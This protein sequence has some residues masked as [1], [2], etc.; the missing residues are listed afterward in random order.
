M[1]SNLLSNRPND[2]SLSFVQKTHSGFQNDRDSYATNSFFSNNLVRASLFAAG[3]YGAYKA[4]I[5]LLETKPKYLQ[6]ITKYTKLFEDR[7][8]NYIGRTFGIS[9]NRISP[10]RAGIGA[11]GEIETLHFPKAD[12]LT[13]SGNLSALGHDFQRKFGDHYDVLANAEEGLSFTRTS[14]SS[15]YIPFDNKPGMSVSFAD[16]KSGLAGT[17]FRLKKPLTEPKIGWSKSSSLFDRAYENLEALKRSQTPKSHPGGW[18]QA[19]NVERFLPVD[20]IKLG[21]EGETF[22]QKTKRVSSNVGQRLEIEGLNSAERGQKLL[23]DTLR[24]GLSQGTY[25][26]LA[27]I[28]GLAREGEKG[29]INGLLLKRVLPLYLGYQALKYADYLTGHKVSNAV[30]DTPLKLNVARAELTDRLPGARKVTDFYQNVVPGKQYAPLALPL[31]GAFLGGLGHYLKVAKGGFENPKLRDEASKLLPDLKLLKNVRNL[32][33]L[34]TGIQSVWKEAGTP[35]K[36]LLLGLAAMVPFIPGMLGSRKSAAEL[37]DIYSGEQDVPIRSGRFWSLGSTPF[38]GARITSWRPH[39]S[40]LYK[41]HSREKSLY[42]SE[43]NYWKH[44]PILHP[45]NAL[46]DPYYLENLHYKDRPYP[47]TSPAGSNIPLIG[48]LVAA[49]LGKL[50]KPVKRMHE[51]EFDETDYDMYST[52]LKPKGPLVESKFER[53]ILKQLSQQGYNTKTQV[54]ADKYRIDFVVEGDDGKKLAIEADGDTYHTAWNAKADATRQKKLESLGYEFIH[55]RSTPYFKDPEN[56]FGQVVTELNK[57]GIKPTVSGDRDVNSGLVGLAPPKPKEE[58]GLWSAIKEEALIASEFI[59]LPGYTARILSQKAFPDNNKGKTAYLQ[60]SRQMD[61]LARSYYESNLGEGLGPNFGSE[62][63][64]GYTEPIRRFIQRD[65]AGVQ[66]NDIPNTMPS[67]LPGEDYLTN[68]RTGD[69]FTK[70]D[71]GY[72]RLPGA[73]YEALHPE[74]EG[75]NPEDYPDFTKLKILADVAPYSREFNQF[76][77]RVGKFIGDDTEKRIEYEQIL[78][79]A[80]QARESI[81]QTDKRHFTGETEQIKGTVKY[82]NNHAVEL[83]EFPGRTFKYSSLGM[84]AADMAAVVIGQHNNYNKSEVANEVKT[85]QKA[86]NA[87]LAAKLKPGTSVKAIISKGAAENSEQVSAVFEANGTNINRELIDLGYAQFNKKN[88]GAETKEL[89]GGT[90]KLLGSVS[91][92]LSYD[93]P[94]YVP[95]PYHTKLWQERTVY[96]Q[97]VSQE[98]VGTRMRR[99]DRPFD[100]FATPYARSILNKATGIKVM[101]EST[102]QRRDLNTLADQLKYIRALHNIAEGSGDE[103]TRD[104]RR[105][106]IGTNLLAS[107]IFVAS[108]IPDRDKRYFSS[109]LGETDPEKRVKVLKVASPEMAKTLQAQWAAADV[110]LDRASG[111]DPGQVESQGRLLT[112]DNLKDYSK[113][114]TKLGYGDYLRSKEI[115]DFFSKTGFSLPEK[116]TDQLYSNNLDYEDVKLK[117]IENEGYDYHDFNIFDDRATT[118]WRKPYVD[119]AVRSLTSGDTSSSSEQIRRSIE[120]LMLQANNKNPKVNVLSQTSS[121]DKN[122]VKINIDH[123]DQ[124]KLMK[125][126]R[127]NP[128]DYQN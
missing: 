108:T 58:F 76:K 37:K 3:G 47:I 105:T 85:R 106:N 98:V 91:E 122:S 104:T 103:Y 26:R 99:W 77:D 89:F 13:K 94:N 14:K 128:E 50:I 72:A 25:N 2:P 38:S 78:D 31:A 18:N 66:A 41:S 124:G 95:T 102:L 120:Q 69:P 114:N 121:I 115:S 30:V 54:K 61:S 57:H 67:W 127:R 59:G 113:A 64:I 71:Q 33:G 109:F 4:H 35:A 86:S 68:F 84:S 24:L 19:E 16:S 123:D 49:T 46:K 32:E 101:S 81:L 119:G 112:E 53:D 9:Q 74:L 110:R 7:T 100:D 34:K 17:A 40:L 21:Q 111:K 42:G 56:A 52:R 87:Y 107:P 60:G 44:N 39:W 126:I 118:L 96:D 75:V 125:D 5:N 8:P 11:S 15:M 80:K 12:L 55:V 70:L 117:I 29:L 48:P 23:A 90:G 1:A 62:E 116:G 45:I 20:A 10:F 63:A 93:V 83:S 6:N 27:T 36:G 28:P 73:G 82:A 92:F 97:Y 43:S 22:W 79:Q 65:P 51:D 88:G